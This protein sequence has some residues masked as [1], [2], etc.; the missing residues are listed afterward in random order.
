MRKSSPTSNDILC[1]AFLLRLH[2]DPLYFLHI[3]P[4]HP[5]TVVI[6]NRSWIRPITPSMLAQKTACKTSSSNTTP[7]YLFLSAANT[8]LSHLDISKSFSISV[9]RSSH[10]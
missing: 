9:Q 5:Q 8:T 4:T 2:K 1:F 6:Y 7:G 3:E 10:C